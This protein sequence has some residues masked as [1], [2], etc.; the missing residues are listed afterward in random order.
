MGSVS[1]SHLIIFIASLLVAA[2]VAGT[3]VT[4]VEQVSSSVDRQSEDI[5]RQIDTD[6]AIISDPSS[7]A[8]YDEQ[9]ETVS[10]LVKNTGRTP[11]EANGSSLD[12]LI[13]GQYRSGPTVTVV[14][15]ESRWSPGAVATV[16]VPVEGGLDAGDH[17]ATV[18]VNGSRATFDFRF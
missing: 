13:D 7:D 6:V 16:T 12:T 4:G 18:I 14:S 10:L 11:I 8:V 2:S 3:L 15:G 17:R 1:I 9:A 5:T